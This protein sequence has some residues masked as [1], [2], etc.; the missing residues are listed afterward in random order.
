MT[1]SYNQ[2]NASA[3]SGS[4]YYGTGTETLVF[5]PGETS[6]TVRIAIIDDLTEEPDQTFSFNLF[7]PVNATIGT[8]SVVATI[9][10]DEPYNIWHKGLSNDTYTLLAATD[11]IVEAADG[12]TDTV[13][14]AFTYTLDPYVENLT[15][16]GTAPINGTGNAS[17]N[18]LLGNGVANILTGLG[19][20]D[21]LDG[22]GGADT[23]IGGLGDDVY[24]V[25]NAG[26]VVTEAANAGT[27]RVES[28]ISYTLGANVENLWLSG[29]AAVNVTGNSLNNQLAGNGAANILDGWQAP[30]P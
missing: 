12:G 5:A 20:N 1:V 26:D 7:S 9:W 11:R 30:T 18:V 2:S 23:M 8:P 17:D 6:K 3:T 15:L 24:R 21:T 10:D 27:D 14:S 29:T 13:N 19:G 28:T 25:D 16:T 4:D 22:Q